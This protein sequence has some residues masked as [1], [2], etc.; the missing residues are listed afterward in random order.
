M[1][2]PAGSSLHENR[3]ATHRPLGLGL[4]ARVP[5]PV[6]E[7]QFEVREDGGDGGRVPR[8]SGL[9]GASTRTPEVDLRQSHLTDNLFA[10]D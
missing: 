3:L 10:T 8:V 2:W 9:S 5:A 7:E 1:R 6:Q 4:I